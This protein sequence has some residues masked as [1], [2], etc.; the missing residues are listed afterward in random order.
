[1][2]SFCQVV[3]GKNLSSKISSKFVL[4]FNHGCFEKLF[5]CVHNILSTAAT[6]AALF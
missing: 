5:E 6:A 1:M 3:V 2:P 4:V